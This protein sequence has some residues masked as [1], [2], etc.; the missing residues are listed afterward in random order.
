MKEELNVENKDIKDEK[1]EI[2]AEDCPCPPSTC[3]VI[4]Y[5][6]LLLFFYI[7]YISCCHFRF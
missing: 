5:K 4:N 6:L 3:E 1:E 2:K 7:F